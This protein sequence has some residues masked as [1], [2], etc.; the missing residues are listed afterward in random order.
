MP[1][2]RRSKEERFSEAILSLLMVL[3]LGWFL[4]PQVRG[5]EVV[6]GLIAVVAG[7]L[8][9]VVVVWFAKRKSTKWE[10]QQNSAPPLEPVQA[11]QT[12]PL[13]PYKRPIQATQQA[14]L[15]QL[16]PALLSDL[17]WCSFEILVTLYFQRSGYLARRRRAGPD[18]GVDIELSQLGANLPYAYV[19]CKA[20]HAYTVGIKP[21]RE[22]FGVMAA[23][24]VTLGFFV[25]TGE[26]TNEAIAFA[27][28][29]SLKLITGRDLIKDLNA[30]PEAER[31]AILRE[32]IARDYTTPTCPRCDVKMVERQGS[33]GTFWGCR[34]YPRCRQTF[35]LRKHA[36]E[37]V[38]YTAAG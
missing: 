1:R 11:F 13:S 5:V 28:G 6:L 16:T 34:K 20:W 22:L 31:I 38:S 35:P 12:A 21:V 36:A 24:K 29:K 33:R 32:I 19:Q 37:D 10:N 18:G 25:T 2:R 30:L 27:H 26:F 15:S 4:L 14:P 8:Y 17:E 7:A 3:G 23:D 9:L